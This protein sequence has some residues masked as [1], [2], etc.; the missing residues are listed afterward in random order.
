MCAR[1]L[2][3][4]SSKQIH[5]RGTTTA[6]AA[7]SRAVSITHSLILTHKF[8]PA[9]S[10]I[11]HPFDRFHYTFDIRVP[12]SLRS[13]SF[14]CM[15]FRTKVSQINEQEWFVWESSAPK[16]LLLHTMR[17]RWVLRIFGNKSLKYFK[18]IVNAN[19]RSILF[20]FIPPFRRAFSMR[21]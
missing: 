4:L 12:N 6:A 18:T 16:N 9:I 19:C 11:S 13:H 21:D 14:E 15:L 10:P 20:D 1:V 3:Q 17:I 5:G 2:E 7:T 8:M